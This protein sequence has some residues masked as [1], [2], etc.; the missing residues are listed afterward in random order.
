MTFINLQPAFES[1]NM[2]R[3]VGVLCNIYQCTTLSSRCLS[4]FFEALR[5]VATEKHTAHFRLKYSFL[6]KEFF[7]SLTEL[8]ACFLR[9]FESILKIFIEEIERKR[10]HNYLAMAEFLGFVSSV[11][12]WNTIRE[13][14]LSS[15]YSV[16]SEGAIAV[17]QDSNGLNFYFASIK[18]AAVFFAMVYALTANIFWNLP[19]AVATMASFY[20]N[21]YSR[22]MENGSA[23]R[24][25]N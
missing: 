19:S 23:R 1:K 4:V 20:L 9:V 17:R 10:A 6:T 16:Q 25:V 14:L 2:V 11:V 18:V 3:T 15:H 21:N 7:L 13:E 8:L 12:K 24:Y 5:L 22:N